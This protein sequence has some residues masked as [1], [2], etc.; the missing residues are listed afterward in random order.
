MFLTEWQLQQDGDWNVRVPHFLAYECEQNK[1]Q[2]RRGFLIIATV[3]SSMAA[4]IAS[5]VERLLRSDRRDE[6]DE[7][8]KNWR[9][10]LQQIADESEPWV[11]ARVRGFLGTIDR[12]R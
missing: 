3:M 1:D 10:S 5:P 12:K 4:D 6:V 9:K 2:E 7:F 11:A 8:L